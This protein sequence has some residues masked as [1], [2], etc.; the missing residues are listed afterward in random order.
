V[1][2]FLSVRLTQAIN[3][4]RLNS[5]FGDPIGDFNGSSVSAGFALGATMRFVSA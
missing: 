4:G 5:A 2:N 3:L 1:I